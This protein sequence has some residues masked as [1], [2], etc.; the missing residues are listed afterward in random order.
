MQAREEEEEEA[1]ES[2][3]RR[4]AEE[5]RSGD[6]QLKHEDACVGK[7]RGGRRRRGTK[8]KIKDQR[9]LREW[10]WDQRGKGGV[11]QREI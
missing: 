1:I 9:W 10:V 3:R 8:V 5:L 7:P 6:W 11:E 4:S 2:K